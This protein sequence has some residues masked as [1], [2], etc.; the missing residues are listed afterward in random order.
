MRWN[1][2]INEWLPMTKKLPVFV[3]GAAFMT[4]V[5]CFAWAQSVEAATILSGPEDAAAALGGHLVTVNNQ[6][7]NDWVFDMFALFGAS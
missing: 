3:R 2:S 7:E 5:A 6:D 4:M 1:N